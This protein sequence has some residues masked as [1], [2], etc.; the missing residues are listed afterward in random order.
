MVFVVYINVLIIVKILTQDYKLRL[1][2]SVYFILTGIFIEIIIAA[3]TII[4]VWYRLPEDTTILVS[5]LHPFTPH[6]MDIFVTLF[7]FLYLFKGRKY[8]AKKAVILTLS[9]L[10]LAAII[11]HLYS[12]IMLCFSVG[13]TITSILLGLLGMYITTICLTTLFVRFSKSL[14]KDINQN[15]PMQTALLYIVILLFASFQALVVFGYHL[16]YSGYTPN[17]ILV[18]GIF[19][20]VLTAIAFIIFIMLAKS[21]EAKYEAQTKE[22]ERQSLELYTAELER[23]QAAIW[24]FKHD[25][26]NILISIGSFLDEGDL[27]GLKQYHATHTA[28]ASQVITGDSIVLERLSKIKVREVKSIIAVKLMTAQNLGLTATFEV[29]EEIDFIPMDSIVLVRMLGIILDNAIEE[30][31]EICEGRIWIGCFKRELAIIFIVQNT[32]RS[33]IPELHKLLKAGFSTKGENRGLGL[34]NLIELSDSQPNISL[35]TSIE[36]G[37]FT[38][39]LMINTQ[40]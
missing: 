39:K 12:Y 19:F 28:M 21:L 16:A 31:T 33:D 34:A 36:E 18:N 11:D 24:K 1:K 9:A 26:Q 5:D 38:Q 32:C 20:T 8:T 13:T 4:S 3:A 22:A 37:N 14:R 23:N 29:N 27:D 35:E 40:S 7:L 30:L 2:E 6:F 25:Y 15:K 17:I 10:L